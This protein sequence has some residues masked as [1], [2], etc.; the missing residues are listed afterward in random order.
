M[1]TGQKEKGPGL[2][3]NSLEEGKGVNLEPGT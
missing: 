2:L 1:V 3:Q